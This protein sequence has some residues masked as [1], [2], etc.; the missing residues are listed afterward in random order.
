V[1]FYRYVSRAD[2]ITISVWNQKSVHKRRGFLGCVKLLASAIQRLKDTGCKKLLTSIALCGALMFRT[3]CFIDQRLD[4]SKD[5]ETDD[6]IVVRGQVVG[7]AIVPCSSPRLMF[8]GNRIGSAIIS[9]HDGR[10]FHYEGFAS[11]FR[12][13]SRMIALSLSRFLGEFGCT[14]GPIT[15]G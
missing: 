10:R 7:E 6:D 2:S 5:S 9:R 11:R 3:V 15:C 1:R 8:P 13:V 14:S 4:L 12:S